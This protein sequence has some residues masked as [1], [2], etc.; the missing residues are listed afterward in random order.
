MDQRS[1][2]PDAYASNLPSAGLINSVRIE[3]IFGK[4]KEIGSVV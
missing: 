3:N 4:N 1:Y 2:Q